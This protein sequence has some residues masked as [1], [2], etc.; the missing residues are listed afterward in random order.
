MRVRK[1]SSRRRRIIGVIN[2]AAFLRTKLGKREVPFLRPINRTPQEIL[3][4]FVVS[5]PEGRFWD[6]QSGWVKDW[7]A[8]EQFTDPPHF[9][10]WLECNRLALRLSSDG[11]RCVVAAFTGPK[12][13]VG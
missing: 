13:S 12:V 4:C 7:R 9:D 10:P 2:L 5:N 1:K 11:F 8:A 3:D 6:G